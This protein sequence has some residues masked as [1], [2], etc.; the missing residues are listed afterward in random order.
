MELLSLALANHWVQVAPESVCDVGW[1][2]FL[3]PMYCLQR[4][5]G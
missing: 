5:E 2:G 1:G 4:T 3:Q